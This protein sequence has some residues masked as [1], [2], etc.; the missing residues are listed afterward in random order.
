MLQS[1]EWAATI[2]PV[3]V[4]VLSGNIDKNYLEIS[5]TSNVRRVEFNDVDYIQGLQ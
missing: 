5:P 2:M 4:I 3:Y 1:T